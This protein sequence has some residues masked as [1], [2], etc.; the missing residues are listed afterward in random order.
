MSEIPLKLTPRLEVTIGELSVIKQF[1]IG[2]ISGMEVCVEN[3]KLLFQLKQN[4]VYT[5]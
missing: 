5:I 2:G 3:D 4:M 1:Q